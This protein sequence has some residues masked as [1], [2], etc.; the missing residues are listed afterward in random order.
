MRIEIEIENPIQMRKL[1]I[2]INSIKKK[3]WLHEI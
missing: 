3:R 1:I 2:L